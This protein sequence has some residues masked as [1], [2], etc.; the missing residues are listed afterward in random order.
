MDEAL[1]AH[2]FPTGQRLEVAQGD[3]TAETTDAIVNAANRYLEHGSGV[4]GAIVRRGGA[5]IQ[6]ESSRWVSEHGLVTHSEPAYT[7]AGNLPCRYVIHAV[8]PVWGEGNEEA[9]LADTIRGSLRLAEHLSLTSISFPAI[10]TGIYHFPVPLAA[11]VILAT[12]L[13]YLADHPSCHLELIR[14][15]LYDHD[16]WQAFADALEQ[17]DHLNP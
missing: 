3:I 2:N 9:T 11:Q 5:Q 1:K 6:A 10:S 14:L 8:G 12:F 13:S 7:R 16:T 17:D 15:V 4:A